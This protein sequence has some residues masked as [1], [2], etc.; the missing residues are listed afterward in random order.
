MATGITEFDETPVLTG[1]Y[2]VC[3]HGRLHLWLSEWD[4][5]LA[6]TLI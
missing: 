4:P 2:S 6:S 5:L 3:E 1:S